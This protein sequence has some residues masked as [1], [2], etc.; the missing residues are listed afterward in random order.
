MSIYDYKYTSIENRPMQMSQYQGK[1]VLIVNT[2][3]KY[4]FTPQYN[5]FTV[6]GFPY[7]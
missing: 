6:I 3:G 4:G 2:A 5:G 1:V 7:R